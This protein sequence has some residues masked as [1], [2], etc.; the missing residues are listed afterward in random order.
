MIVVVRH[1]GSEAVADAI[2]VSNSPSKPGAEWHVVG[3]FAA[4]H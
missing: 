3:C 1:R 4:R 2:P